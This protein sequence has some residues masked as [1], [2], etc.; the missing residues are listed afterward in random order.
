M[1]AWIPEIKVAGK[2]D[3][4]RARRPDSKAHSR[5]TIA[6]LNVR[7][8]HVP[9][10][11]QSAFAM[12]V[13]VEIGDEGRK[14][15]RIVHGLGNAIG[16]RSPQLVV[17]TVPI[18]RGYE[19]A[20]RVA[21][22]HGNN[23]ILEH[24][25]AGSSRRQIST[26][27]PSGRFLIVFELVRTKDAKRV[28]MVSV[29]DFFDVGCSHD[30]IMTTMIEFIQQLPKAELHVHLEGSIEPETLLEICPSLTMDQVRQRYT[31][32]TFT[33]FLQNF[34]WVARH[35]Q[36]PED[37]AIATRRLLERLEQQNVRYAEINLSAGVVLWKDQDLAA[38]HDAV[39]A[40]AAESPIETQ[41]IWDAV[42][43]W[44]VPAAQ[45]VAEMAAERVNDG[46]V[47]FGLG[48]DESN[49]AAKDFA[50]PFRYAK[51]RGLRLV[52]HAGEVLGSESVW[53]A[54]E[55]GAERIGHG[56]GAMEDSALIRYMADTKVPVEICMSSNVCTGAIA[57]LQEH[58]VRK[59]FDAGVPIILNTDDPPMFHTTLAREYEI[60]AEVFGFT[61][62]ELAQVAAN[63]FQYAFRDPHSSR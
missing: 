55:V 23:T 43:Q 31:Y 9:R 1:H 58:P 20:F 35:L 38:V 2:T 10:F 18:Q 49:G 3:A 62:P 61:E 26:N 21:L 24:D 29:H 60:A 13:Y 19:E 54:L 12:K 57:R 15:I 39:R 6:S 8:E 40:A 30:V 56:V 46:V 63:G 5:H 22:L 42:R 17:G 41:W 45:R 33:G 44:G 7:A 47:A 25:F 53:Q 48:G 27:L 37:Y 59:L 51:D 50:G 36:K 4:T 11:L 16:V 14:A 28:A 52:C 32:D 34:G